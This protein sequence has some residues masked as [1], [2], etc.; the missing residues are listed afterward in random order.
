MP[1]IVF[2]VSF[3]GRSANDNAER[4]P[5]AFAASGWETVR[6]GHES[7]AL[8]GRRLSGADEGGRRQDL[9]GAERYF[10]LGFGAAA[11]FL[12]RM[13][14][15]AALDE[16]RFVNTP[17]ALVRQHGKVSLAIDHP[18][19]PQPESHLSNDPRALARRVASGGEWIGKPP[20]G[21][22]GRDVFL[23]HAGDGN[24]SAILEHLTRDGRYALLQRRV[25][26]DGAEKRVLVA[27]GEVI[28]AYG[29]AP[30]DHRGNLDAGA[31][32]RKGE[33]SGEERRTAARLAARLAAKGVRF[34]AIDLAW[35]YF[36]EVNVANPGWLQTFEALTG[37]DLSPAVAAALTVDAGDRRDPAAV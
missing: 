34:A 16:G 2:L 21:S 37:D 30:E 23:L 4:L 26:T 35:P 22:F 24:T 29:K 12:D 27:G 28:G 6:I 1:R 31:R 7:L 11:T 19:I 25:P 5:R 36:L 17:G 15:L 8:E 33:L 18:D 3:D 13:Q 9:Q 14:M 10:I 32:P 20:A